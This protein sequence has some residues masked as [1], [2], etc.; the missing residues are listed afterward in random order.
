MILMVNE[1]MT[2]SLSGEAIARSLQGA[3]GR[4]PERGLCDD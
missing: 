2:G 1:A 3:Q 4:S